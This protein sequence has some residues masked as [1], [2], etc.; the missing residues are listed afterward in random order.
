VDVYL[1][2]SSL[3]FQSQR[4]EESIQA[5]QAALR[6]RPDVAGAYANIAAGLHALGR[7]DEAVTALREVVRLRPDLTFAKTDMQVL[8]EQKAGA[9]R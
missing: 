7:D 4:Y 5:A 2:L 8:P 3:Y 6:L 1:K 9:G